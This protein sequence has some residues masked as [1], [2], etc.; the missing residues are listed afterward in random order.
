[1]IKWISKHIFVFL[2]RMIVL[3][4]ACWAIE[5]MVH[6]ELGYRVEFEPMFLFMIIAIVTLRVWMPWSIISRDDTQ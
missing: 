5:G 1:M 4:V 2:I 6:R 3:F